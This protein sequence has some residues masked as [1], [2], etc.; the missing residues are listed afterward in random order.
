MK[1][2]QIFVRENMECKKQY[3]IKKWIFF[4]LFTVLFLN[5]NTPSA[6]A[7]VWG[8]AYGAAL[9]KQQM[10]VVYTEMQAAILGTLKVA[11]YE[12][13]HTQMGQLIGGS[14]YKESLIISDWEDFVIRSPEKEA[15]VYMNDFFSSTFQGKN[16]CDYVPLN[17]SSS[18]PFSNTVVSSCAT[19]QEGV[20]FVQNFPSY[21][22]DYARASIGGVV[23]EGI[24]TVQEYTLDQF[25]D[26]PSQM[27]S[28]GN[29]KCWNA[30]FS[31]DYN[32][33]YGYAVIAQKEYAQEIEKNQRLAELKSVAYQGYKPQTTEDGKYVVT[34][35]SLIKDIQSSVSD[36]G[37]KIIA[38]A[39]SP[40]EFLS[41]LATSFVTSYI[42]QTIRNGVG[43][44]QQHI[45]S[46]IREVD[47]RMLSEV[48]RVVDELGPSA[49][50]LPLYQSSG[51]EW[52][53]YYKGATQ[54]TGA[55]D[56]N[57]DNATEY[58]FTIQCVGSCCQDAG[59]GSPTRCEST[60]S[61]CQTQLDFVQQTISSFNDACGVPPVSDPC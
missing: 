53:F 50:T 2:Q 29:W 43:E 25:C 34:P 7:D 17:S 59:L 35:G 48:N 9:V 18:D 40:G 4:A 31:N 52:Q 24:D 51:E 30:F 60:K 1:K 3:R 54:T 15:G 38:A 49:Q 47:S 58:C 28:S 37:N 8:A 12:L 14:N 32:N 27:F 61:A 36:L 55:T 5:G 20:Q 6:R 10:E 42:Q 46:E 21:L 56:T 44:I 45:R 26:D 23:A 22:E 41:A 16:G 57:S 19:V 33:P 13:L 39:N 11:A